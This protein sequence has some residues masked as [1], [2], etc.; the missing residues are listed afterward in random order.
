MRLAEVLKLH[1]HLVLFLKQLVH[2]WV[3]ES[4]HHNRLDIFYFILA[5]VLTVSVHPITYGLS[6]V[7][8]KMLR[9][10]ISE[11]DKANTCETFPEATK[12][13]KNLPDQISR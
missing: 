1:V 9:Q 3:R 4:L 2:R 6:L 10:I 12:V 11:D 7:P 8:S 13:G 5:T